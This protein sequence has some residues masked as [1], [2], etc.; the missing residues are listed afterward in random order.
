MKPV[1]FSHLS[2][3]LALVLAPTAASAQFICDPETDQLFL[4]AGKSKNVLM[5]SGLPKTIDT[6]VGA[7]K[8]VFDCDAENGPPK[9]GTMNCGVS[10]QKIL[11]TW[12]TTDGRVEAKCLSGTYIPAPSG[13]TEA[14]AG[15]DAAETSGKEH[16]DN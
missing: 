14:T 13:T 4:S 9:S 2:I 6:K 5:R 11:I 7:P 15:D 3:T 16:T 12:H 8:I 1:P 10:V